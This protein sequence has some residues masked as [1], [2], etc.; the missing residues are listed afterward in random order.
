MCAWTCSLLSEPI[1]NN[2]RQPKRPVTLTADTRKVSNSTPV[3]NYKS[4]STPQPTSQ[5][6]LK[7]EP[8]DS[9][10][11]SSY[12]A[13]HTSTL[14][15]LNGNPVFPVTGKPLLST[16]LDTDFGEDDKPWRKPGADITD[17]FNYGFDEFT[18]ASYCLKKSEMPKEIKEIKDNAEQMKNFLE[19]MGGFPGGG[20]PGIPGMP[21]AAGQPPAGP[22]AQGG[23]N[24]PSGAGAQNGQQNAMAGMPGMPSEAEMQQMFQAMMAQGVDPGQMDPNQFMQ[25]MM[26]G[27]QPGGAGG[28]GGQ[29]QPPAGPAMGGFGGNGF[30]QGGGGF[31]GGG[32]GRGRGRRG[33]GNW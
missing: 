28:F 11:G 31:G 12:P 22:V 24:T 17:F 26:G 2:A 33:R 32:G 7:V 1:T 18:W 19:G 30:D 16:D 25:M 9:R 21:V 3:P 29:Q 5:Q 15:P 13:R 6:D 4:E 8:T 14:D 27:G 10:P 23:V 20:M